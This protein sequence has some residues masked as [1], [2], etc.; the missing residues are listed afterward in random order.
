MTL[1]GVILLTYPCITALSYGL[2]ACPLKKVRLTF[3]RLRCEQIL[4]EIV[5]YQRYEYN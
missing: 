5:Q 3:S 2:E 1:N 4:Y